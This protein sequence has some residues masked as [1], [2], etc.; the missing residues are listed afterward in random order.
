MRISLVGTRMSLP[1]N[2]NIMIKFMQATVVFV[3]LGIT[4]AIWLGIF[5]YAISNGW[6]K[7]KN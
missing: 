7:A 2:N 5:T 1:L 3:A 6:H 4:V